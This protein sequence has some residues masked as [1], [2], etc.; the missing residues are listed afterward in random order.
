MKIV[1][2]CPKCCG[3]NWIEA[4]EAGLFQC[5]SCGE[6][7][8]PETMCANVVNEIKGGTSE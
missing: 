4:N 1:L 8:E 3:E 7:V 6:I 5:E 2:T